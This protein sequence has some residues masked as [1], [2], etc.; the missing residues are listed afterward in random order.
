[1]PPPVKVMVAR[2]PGGNME[3]AD[4]TDWLIPTVIT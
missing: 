2:F 4:T 1:M 3:H